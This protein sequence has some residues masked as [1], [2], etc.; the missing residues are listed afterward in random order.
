MILGFEDL[1]P[2]IYKV[3]LYKI[4]SG[5]LDYAMGFIYK[6]IIPVVYWDANAMPFKAIYSH[7][8]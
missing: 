6:A 2:F 3:L 1:G 8:S 4:Y 5:Q 7:I